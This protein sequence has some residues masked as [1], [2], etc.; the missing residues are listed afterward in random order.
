MYLILPVGIDFNLLKLQMLKAAVY[1]SVNEPLAHYIKAFKQRTQSYPL[2]P[3]QSFDTP[4]P[5]TQL[6]LESPL[7]KSSTVFDY[8]P[9]F[10]KTLNSFRRSIKKRRSIYFPRTLAAPV[11]HISIKYHPPP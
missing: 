5:R 6:N 9:P 1:F 8:L 4:I 11:T 2:K 7:F 3:G 10:A